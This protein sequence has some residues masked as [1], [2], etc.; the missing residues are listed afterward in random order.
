MSAILIIVI[1]ISR[2]AAISIVLIAMR[3]SESVVYL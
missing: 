3:V 1:L 2:D